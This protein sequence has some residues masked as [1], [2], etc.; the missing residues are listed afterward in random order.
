MGRG[1]GQGYEYSSR[2][3][4]P[5]R[6][7]ISDGIIVLRAMEVREQAAVGE[8]RDPAL[9][10]L[11]ANF[12]GHS[13]LSAIFNPFEGENSVSAFYSAGMTFPPTD[14]AGE[15]FKRETVT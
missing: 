14:R 12:L 7:S 6:N 4:R 13:R 8:E 1:R 2:A 5:R 15:G 11:S 9:S 10:D 3:F